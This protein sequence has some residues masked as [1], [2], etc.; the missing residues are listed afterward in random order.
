MVGAVPFRA[1]VKS[2]AVSNW[3][4]FVS[5]GPT[6]ILMAASVWPIEPFPLR[7]TIV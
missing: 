1:A 2:D 4:K 7:N 5:S 6:S 3:G